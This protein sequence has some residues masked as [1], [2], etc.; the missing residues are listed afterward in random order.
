LAAQADPIARLLGPAWQSMGYG[1]LAD[2]AQ[3]LEQAAHF[4]RTLTRHMADVEAE[5]AGEALARLQ[6]SHRLQQAEWERPLET[7]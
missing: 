1:T 7:H 3:Q 5:T 2:R 6:A 4:A